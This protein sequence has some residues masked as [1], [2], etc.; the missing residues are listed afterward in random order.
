MPRACGRRQEDSVPCRD[1]VEA[2]TPLQSREGVLPKHQ[3]Q[4]DVYK[5]DRELQFSG[6]ETEA[7]KLRDLP[8]QRLCRK[9]Q[10]TQGGEG[11]GDDNRGAQRA[12]TQGA[13]IPGPALCLPRPFNLTGLQSYL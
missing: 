12:V 7:A 10:L 11:T 5:Q 13:C 3:I 6:A 9:G 8:S 4:A 2:E 1:R